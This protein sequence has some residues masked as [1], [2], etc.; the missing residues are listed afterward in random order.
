VERDL[1]EHE[2]RRVSCA[3]PR[4]STD[5]AVDPEHVGPDDAAPVLDRR[6]LWALLAAAVIT[7]LVWVTWVHPPED[8]LF[9]D[10]KRYVERAQGLALHGMTPGRRAMAWQTWGTHVILAVPLKLLG[11]VPLPR[12]A[13][14]LWA[15]FSAGTVVFTYLLAAR[16]LG[17]GRWSTGVG[18]VALLWYPHLSQ[19]G[20]FLAET[21][22]ACLQ[23]ATTWGLIRLLQTGR[24]ALWI[25]PAASVAFAVRP[26]IAIFFLLSLSV[27]AWVRR[28]PHLHTPARPR[29]VVWIG[30]VLLAM[31]SVSMWRFHAH[32]GRWAGVA[33]NANM[34][35]TA[36]RCHNI[37]TQAF[38]SER[39]MQRSIER[40][41]TRDGRRVSLPGFRVLDLRLD[42]DNPFGLRPAMGSRT[43]RFVGYVGD[44]EIHRGLR[45]QCY[46][47]TGFLEQIRYSV[48]NVSLLWFWA[49]QF[50]E[51]SDPKSPRALYVTA[52][53]YRYG[54]AI[55]VLLPS[56]VGVV[57]AWRRRR[58]DPRWLL[59]VAQLAVSIG[60][61]A[62]FFGTIRL[63]TPY[64]SFSFILAAWAIRE[65]LR[66]WGRPGPGR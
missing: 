17:P 53:V 64:D 35:F 4:E 16:L 13:A 40:E 5:P 51:V 9:S 50:P 57:M 20:Y 10:M 32:T 1:R 39:A 26:Q 43:L 23:V 66:R 33:E 60:V 19:A 38:K 61:A 45:A 29:A 42:H 46:A 56:M 12:A 22:F 7:R 34:N 65:G 6:V 41:S 30:V 25:G 8:Y 49:D 27:W 44:P 21:P 18:L 62:V 14:W 54:F 59:L 11:A 55:G 37:V 47:Q 28:S 15:S 58:E 52:A 2:R 31:L 36:G 3:V 24:G 48:V 63:R